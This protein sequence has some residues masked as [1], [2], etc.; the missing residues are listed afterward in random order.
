VNK[1]VLKKH[2]S[3]IATTDQEKPWKSIARDNNT[4]VCR[5]Y[6]CCCKK[7]TR[8]RNVTGEKLRF[9]ITGEF[10]TLLGAPCCSTF[11]TN[12]SDKFGNYIEQT[13]Q[14]RYGKEHKNEA[15]FMLDFCDV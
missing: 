3:V 14:W 5:T 4:L 11:V 8:T 2:W 15:Y 10:R 13:Q 12:L 6:G 7:R 9:Y 1:R